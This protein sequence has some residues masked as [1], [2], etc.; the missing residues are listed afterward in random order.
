MNKYAKQRNAGALRRKLL[1]LLVAGCFAGMASANPVGPQVV[2]GQVGF[3]SQGNTLAITNTPG[4]IIN[5]Q[6]FSINQGEITRF[7]QQN[8]GSTVLNRITGQD[9]S[10]ILGALQSNGHVFLVNPN[11][12]LFGQGAQIDVNGL[13]ASTLNI[14]NEDFLAGRLNFIAGSTAGK[15]TNQASITTPSGGR[16]YL[17]APNVENSGIITSPQGQV[18]LAAGRSVQLVDSADPDLQVVVSAPDNRALNLGSVIAQGGKAGIYGALINQRGIVSADSAVV[19]E[20]GKIVFKASGDT[21]LEAGSRTSATG[22]GHGG[23]IHVLGQHVGLTGDATVDAS[24]QTGGGTVLIGGDYQGKGSVPNAQVTYTGQQAIIKADATGNG[25]GGKVIVWADDTTRSYAHISVRGG[26][27]GGDGGFV[28]TSGKKFLDVGTAFPDVRAPNGK[29]GSWLLDPANITIDG[30]L[31]TNISAGPNFT[32]VGDGASTLNAGTLTQY[33]QT[34]GSAT[35][36]TSTGSGGSGNITVNADILPNMTGDGLLTLHA[37]N[38]IMINAKIGASGHAL[39]VKLQADNYTQDGDAITLGSM[40]SINSNGGMISLNGFGMMSL[41]G[42]ID[43]GGGQV[44]LSA[45]EMAL[46]S[47][48]NASSVSLRTYTAGRSITVGSATCHIDSCLSIVNLYNIFAPTISIGHAAP[49]GGSAP[50]GGSG[51]LAAQMVQVSDTP[52]GPIYVDGITSGGSGPTDRNALT[53]RIDLLSAA[54]VSQGSAGIDVRDLGV[55]AG[56]SG[57]VNLINTNNKVVNLAG[58]TAGSGFNFAN[59]GDLTIASLN[60]G[61]AAGS[62]LAGINAGSG[63]VNLM[64]SGAIK[65][66][67]VSGGKLALSAG[68]GITLATNAASLMASNSGSDSDIAI[69]NNAAGSPHELVLRS[70]MQGGSGKVSVSNVGLLRVAGSVLT[71]TGNITLKAASPLTVDGSVG[72]TSGNI[73]LVAGATGTGSGDTLTVSSAGGVKTAGTVVLAAGDGIVLADPSRVSAGGKL[74][75]LANMNLTGI[76]P[77]LATA[78]PADCLT[79][80]SSPAIV[81]V[82]SSALNTIISTTSASNT[83]PL[84]MS[85]MPPSGTSNDASPAGSSNDSAKPEEKKDGKKEAADTKDN[86]ATKNEPAKKMYCN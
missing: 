16:V 61:T 33:L 58:A 13:V 44:D 10:Q 31:D 65:G 17:I 3:A 18:L 7:I 63:D 43:A 68:R 78:S 51:Q 45:D 79:T 52:A 75:Q 59:S 73:V 83:L 4:A 84:A 37:D 81:A 85:V 57:S 55:V 60:G 23:E 9:P 72:S 67:T 80:T 28:E 47:T 26:E 39:S 41:N 34:N 69:T 24:G 64:S 48:I 40:G 6:S 8:S 2:N 14:S 70:V 32:A 53:T 82:T 50:L 54:D 46:N 30:T 76:N 86:G 36:D 27:Q 74:L 56:G 29:A 35:I 1:P 12:I 21:L 42:A 49:A 5:W 62:S 77:C 22:A 66:G 38:H 19:G 20:N 15:L 71:D 11:G 25:N